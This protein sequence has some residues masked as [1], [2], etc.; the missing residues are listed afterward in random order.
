[1]TPASVA[2]HPAGRV[3]TAWWRQFDAYAPRRLW[4]A[5]LTIRCLDL[6]TVQSRPAPVEPFHRLVLEAIA[7]TAT[8]SQ[9]QVAK[10]L[11]VNENALRLMMSDLIGQ[12]LVHVDGSNEL[13]AESPGVHKADRAES[14]SPEF[15]RQTFRL[16]ADSNRFVPLNVPGTPTDL[17]DD[18]RPAMAALRDCLAQPADWKKRHGF[19]DDLKAILDLDTDSDPPIPIWKRVPI[20]RGERHTLALIQTSPTR[21]LAFPVR[22]D[23][24]V[25]GKTPCLDLEFAVAAE[26]L[27]LADPEPG[28]W[29]ASWRDWCQ[30]VRGVNPAE[31]DNC[32]FERVNH[33]LRVKV[34]PELM[35]QL[36]VARPEVF[37]SEAWL[38]AGEARCRAACRLELS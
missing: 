37:K 5:D 1:M 30:L 33:V 14:R 15:E 7:M 4:F 20:E 27:G 23:G 2:A 38:L 11:G 34:P 13:L 29:R 8:P 18:A 19:P 35:E 26:T 10:R 25:A 9:A 31:V 12:R 17:P 28:A 24:S 6:L 22:L 36:K 21:V 16:L 32:G 3:L